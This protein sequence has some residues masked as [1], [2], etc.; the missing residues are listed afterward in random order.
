MNACLKILKQAHVKNLEWHCFPSLVVGAF[1]EEGGTGRTFLAPPLCCWTILNYTAGSLVTIAHYSYRYNHSYIIICCCAHTLY[2]DKLT[3]SISHSCTSCL[4]MEQLHTED[5]VLPIYSSTQI[6]ALT[7][8]WILCC[9][10]L[11]CTW[12]LYFLFILN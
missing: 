11:L 6:S 4:L 10:L 5:K 8:H 12:L 7:T 3:C 1:K 9:F 2:N